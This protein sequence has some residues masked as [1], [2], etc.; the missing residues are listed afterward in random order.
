MSSS[1]K[2]YCL[3]FIPEAAS[4]TQA[5]ETFNPPWLPQTDKPDFRDDPEPSIWQQQKLERIHDAQWHWTN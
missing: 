1:C 2:I 4:K 5:R 3:L